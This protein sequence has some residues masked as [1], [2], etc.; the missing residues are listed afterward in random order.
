MSD[1]DCARIAGIILAGGASSRMGTPKALLRIGSETFIDHLVATFY[2]VVSPVIV[3]LGHD[4]ELVREGMES[5]SPVTFAVNPQPERGMLSSFQCGLR[6]LPSET[7]AV[8]FTPVDYPS[9]QVVTVARLAAEFR[10][11]TCD[12]VIPRCRAVKGHPV[13]ISWR[14]AEELIEAPFTGQV[15]DVIRRH[16]GTTVFLEVDDPGTTNDVDTPEDYRTLVTS[17]S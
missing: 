14:V 13:C 15:R 11:R 5:R 1:P 3:V 10:S 17:L 7:S 8:I 9:C 12:V 6:V 2:S 4:S 16:I